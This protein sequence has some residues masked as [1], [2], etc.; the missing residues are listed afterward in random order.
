MLLTLDTFLNRPA[1]I[2]VR[3][4]DRGEPAS[5]LQRLRAWPAAIDSR[6]NGQGTGGGI[7]FTTAP[8]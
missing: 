3:P 8:V 6:G 4:C 2:F 5:K 1:T 7:P